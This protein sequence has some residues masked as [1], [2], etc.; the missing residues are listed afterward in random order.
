MITCATDNALTRCGQGLRSNWTSETYWSSLRSGDGTWHWSPLNSRRLTNCSPD[1]CGGG[2]GGRGLAWC[3]KPL[4]VSNQPVFPAEAAMVQ[5]LFL[6]PNKASVKV[7]RRPAFYFARTL[8]PQS[9]MSPFCA[10]LFRPDGGRHS[11]NWCDIIA[12]LSERKTK[13]ILAS[14]GNTVSIYK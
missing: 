5:D 7:V 12:K 11:F 8:F 14:L 13:T 3:Q 9:P 6:A 4:F 10:H 1:S 2:G